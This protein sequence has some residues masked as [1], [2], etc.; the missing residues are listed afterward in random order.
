M[1]LGAPAKKK[2]TD[3]GEI[4]GPGEGA[5]STARSTIRRREVGKIPSPAAEL[6]WTALYRDVRSRK[7]ASV[8]TLRR[9]PTVGR[10]RWTYPILVGIYLACNVLCKL[11]RD[12]KGAV[13]KAN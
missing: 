11:L 1:A 7:S 4:G 6:R 9:T 8:S 2:P 12:H 5:A 3:G 13:C 10:A